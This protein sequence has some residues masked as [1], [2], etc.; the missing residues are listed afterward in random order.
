MELNFESL[1]R[2]K[3]NIPTDRDQRA[4]EKNRG[5]LPSFVKFSPRAIFIQNGKNNSFF[6]FERPSERSYLVLLKN[7][8]ECFILNYHL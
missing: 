2:K 6:L 4:D 5:N 1:K 3:W 7:H 8:V